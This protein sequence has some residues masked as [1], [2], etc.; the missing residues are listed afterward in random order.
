MTQ[1]ALEATD[2]P[3]T[4]PPAGRRVR[5]AVLSYN[6]PR[7]GFKRGGIERVAHE[8]ADG[9]AG[10][11]HRVTVYSHDPRPDGA[12]YQTAE[13]PW[14]SF[15][16]TWAG[17]RAT[18]GYLGNVLNLVTPLGDAEVVIAHGDS[19]LL[20]LRGRPVIRIMHGSALEEAHAAT[21]IGR[22]VLQSG[23]HG[24]E[25]LTAATDRYVVGVSENTARSN[26][27][28]RRIIPNG[29]NLETFFPDSRARSDEPMLLFVGALGGRKRGAW[30]LDEF[31][32][33]IAPRCQGVQLH[34]VSEA[35][36]VIPNVTY[37]TGATDRDLAALYRR[38]WLYVSPST[39]EGFGLPY[40]E[41]LASGTPVV[42]TP[43]PGSL[44]VLGGGGGWL[45]GD[46]EFADTVVRL[47]EDPG[48]R[49]ALARA[50]LERAARFSL[51]RT[52]DAYEQLIAEAID[53]G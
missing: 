44:E 2:V 47:L 35:G 28:V 26:R 38:A 12:R 3:M 23:V 37:H 24:L 20:P 48:E 16:G 1:M 13:L 46:D 43:N 33:R 49:A 8:L 29:V 30:L 10:R 50:G 7:P 52:L 18:M 32:G 11:G 36:P 9:L 15:V 19:V 14:R 27:F 39:Y 6:L 21:S 25:L 22:R 53:R 17:R 4:S 41:A 40:L 45:V 42:A 5:V 34:V 51:E 31:V